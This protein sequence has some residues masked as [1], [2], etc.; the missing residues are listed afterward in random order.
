MSDLTLFP[1]PIPSNLEENID[2]VSTQVSLG[3]D[4]AG[5]ILVTGDD[6][7]RSCVQKVLKVI[8]TEKGSVPTNSTYGTNLI[9]LSK[10]G[11]NPQTITEDIVM[12]LIAAENQCK[13]QDI[14]ASTPV[15]GLIGS[16][17]LL[18]LVLLSTSQLQLSIG[19]KTINGITG[20]FDLQV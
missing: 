11:Y 7:L 15:S 8:L 20:S 6:S 14:Q 3:A 9:G 17:E 10:Y 5:N 12:I 4:N 13:N 16:I 2:Y 19:I 1:V 18:D